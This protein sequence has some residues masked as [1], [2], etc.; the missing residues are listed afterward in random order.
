MDNIHRARATALASVQGSALSSVQGRASSMR[1][2]MPFAAH[3]R[4]L[5][6]EVYDAE[7]TDNLPGSRV[8]CEGDL[9]QATHDQSATNVY[10]HFKQIF[11]FYSGVF[12]R[13]SIDGNGMKI[14]GTVHYDP[15]DYGFSN[16]CWDRNQL[17]FGD[18][19]GNVIGSFANNLDITCHEFAHGVDQYTVG[20]P[21]ENEIGALAESI[22]DVF[23]S[24]VKQYFAPG[25]M[26]KANDADWLIGEGIYLLPS[27]RALRDM[28]HPGTAYDDPR[29]GGRDPQ[30]ATMRNYRHSTND[31]EGDYGGIHINCGIPNR[32][33]C[34]VATSI[35]EYS[36]DVA[37]QIWYKSLT[38][39]RF[40][41]VVDSMTPFK[42][43]AD[44]TCS[45]ALE[46]HGQQA[47]EAVKE[48]WRTVEV[49]DG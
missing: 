43:F 20:L 12:H 40:R 24:M 27:A 21:G 22:S 13:N 4:H 34:L 6:R 28:R 29:L 5:N 45:N 37:G 16:A 32:A 17:V 15:T 31:I 14:V 41:T 23:A 18:G 35:G 36:W 1:T 7:G 3:A 30:P 46:H 9:P 8:F 42:A 49:L 33:F 48:A 11:D 10:G 26:Q 39:D 44:L 25:G 2:I 38:D 47:H 19:D